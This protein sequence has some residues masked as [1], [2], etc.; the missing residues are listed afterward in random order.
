MTAGVEWHPNPF[1][2]DSAEVD[3]VVKAAHAAAGGFRFRLDVLIT[4]TS[5]GAK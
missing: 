2:V 4:G 3:R 5:S 1:I